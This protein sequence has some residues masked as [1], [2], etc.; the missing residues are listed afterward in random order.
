MSDFEDDDPV[1]AGVSMEC[2]VNAERIRRQDKST[3][4]EHLLQEMDKSRQVVTDAQYDAAT[5][6][7]IAHNCRLCHESD[8]H[9]I[10]VDKKANMG[11]DEFIRIFS[12]QVDVRSALQLAATLVE[13]Y[14][15]DDGTL[16]VKHNRSITEFK[17]FKNYPEHLGKHSEDAQSRSTIVIPATFVYKA[18]KKGFQELSAVF[19]QVKDFVG[20]DFALVVSHVLFSSNNSCHFMYHQDAYEHGEVSDL[21][22]IVQLSASKSTFHIAGN[23]TAFEYSKAGSFFAFD[24]KLWHRSGVNCEDT[25][26]IAFF[27]KKAEDATA[28]D[29]PCDT[30]ASSSVDNPV[31]REIEDGDDPDDATNGQPPAKKRVSVM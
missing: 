21:S 16:C 2:L 26:K 18:D 9:I 19:K 25:I 11:P 23:G 12:G 27:F 1:P 20:K 22:V 4:D 31:K 29:A 30:Q 8:V 14:N 13:N 17:G 28:E 15:T 3:S 10:L 24:A 7:M 6:D 5:A